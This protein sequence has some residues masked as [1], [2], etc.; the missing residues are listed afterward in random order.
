MG[1]QYDGMGNVTTDNLMYSY[2]YD[3]EGR[4]VSAEGVT[5][6]CPTHSRGLRMCGK[7]D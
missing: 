7:T 3:A 2:A 4:P 6:G 1:F 5:A